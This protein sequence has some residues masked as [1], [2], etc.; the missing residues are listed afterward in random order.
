[1]KKLFLL[2]V[3]SLC[4]YINSY[5]QATS[6]TVD[7][8]NPGWLSNLIPFNDQQTVENLK[9]SGYVNYSDLEFIG[10]LMSKYS[11][12]GVIDLENVNIV[13]STTDKD[14]IISDCP[15]KKSVK[16]LKFPKT[17]VS[18]RKCIDN[19]KADTIT[20]GGESLP[21][22][23]SGCF[24]HTIIGDD[25]IRF[26]KNVKHLILR[27]GVTTIGRGA[28]YNS[29]EKYGATSSE[30][31]LTSVTLPSTLKKIDELAFAN[32][33][34]LKSINLVDSIT[35]IGKYAFSGDSIFGDTLILPKM[36]TRYILKSFTEQIF[37]S[38][39]YYNPYYDFDVVYIPENVSIVDFSNVSPPDYVEWHIENKNP[40]TTEGL[41]WSEDERNRVTVYVP[42]DRLEVYKNNYEWKNFNIK[43]EPVNVESISLD[44]NSIKMIK[45]NTDYLQAIITPSDADD[46]TIKWYSSNPSIV[47][48][49][50]NGEIKALNT[51]EAFV[52]VMSNENN[53][54][55]DSCNIVVHQPVKSLNIDARLL[56]L[57][58]EETYWFKV[59]FDPSDADN[60][61]VLWSSTDEAVATVDA[62]G[63]VT[64]VN[65][66][67]AWIK[68]ISDDNPEACDSCKVTV[69]QSVTGI[70]M[71]ITECTLNKIGQTVQLTATVL[72][73]NA[74]NKNVNWK[75]SNESVCI[76]SNGKVV[77]VGFGKAVVIAT[78]EEGGYMAI[79]T[80]TV[81]EETA[82]LKGDVNLDGKVDISDVVAVIN[83][84]A[85]DTTFKATSDVN[86][87]GKT[88]IS[89]VVSVINIMAGSSE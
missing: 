4:A 69:S 83:T 27:E 79:C 32:C 15:F 85:G 60:K 74:S 53:A 87:D 70:E 78:T 13:G 33:F 52:Y 9:L 24:Y 39:A 65:P 71:D 17:L 6:L 43:A 45:G 36:L 44:R 62:S 66:G 61:K 76:V 18:A 58:V 30:C 84:M 55:K 75:S 81:E 11:L 35:E 80:V 7:C 2:I 50:Q 26:I 59:T 38:S 25:G 77:A 10:T 12:R 23:S 67:E 28:F 68:A 22:I 72:P 1:M 86:N 47:T 21:V 5:A 73:E 49:S 34:S 41:L 19:I 29:S 8:Q 14:N 40:P 3:L 82:A 56:T 89:D 42:K 20:F 63:M 64:A 31:V 54:I 88:D 57:K 51:G 37:M 16:H 48:V 46:T